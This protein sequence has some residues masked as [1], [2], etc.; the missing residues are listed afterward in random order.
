FRNGD[1]LLY[2]GIAKNER[3]FKEL[4][5]FMTEANRRGKPLPS[6]APEFKE[7]FVIYPYGKFEGQIAE[8]EYIGIRPSE[9]NR[10]RMDRTMPVDRCVVL[11]TVSFE[12]VD[13]KLHTQLRAID[14]NILISQLD[15]AQVAQRDE[16][17]IPRDN[18][19]AYYRDCPQL[20]ANTEQLLGQCGFG[21]V[22]KESKNKKTFTGNR[23]EDKQLLHKYE[24]DGFSRRYD[25]ND[26]IARERVKRELEIIDNLNF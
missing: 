3:G 6:C 22:F 2:V 12:L 7:V 5:D 15:P 9:V 26:K 11:H 16:V 21:F 19:L 23:Y 17:F 4:N 13:F 25:T 24:L 10:F 14:N 8:N 18:L 1:R 20:I